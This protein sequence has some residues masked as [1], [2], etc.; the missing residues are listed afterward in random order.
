MSY[1]FLDHEGLI[2]LLKSRYRKAI[3]LKNNAIIDWLANN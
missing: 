3:V 2:E 1:D